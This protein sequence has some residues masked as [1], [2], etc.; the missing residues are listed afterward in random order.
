MVWPRT[1]LGHDTVGRVRGVWIVEHFVLILV[2]NDLLTAVVQD[3]SDLSQ[4][5]G[6]V[7]LRFVSRKSLDE[8]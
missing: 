8:S 5:R 6:K 4:N 7:W 3:T 2:L 1:N